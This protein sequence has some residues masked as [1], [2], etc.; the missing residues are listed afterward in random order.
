MVIRDWKYVRG[1]ALKRLLVTLVCPGC[2]KEVAVSRAVHSIAAD[3]A[4]TPSMVCPHC[5]FHEWVSL[6]NWVPEAAA[7][8]PTGRE[9]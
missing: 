4:V 9:T 3:G 6:E 7:A 2:G 5:P 8:R 1:P